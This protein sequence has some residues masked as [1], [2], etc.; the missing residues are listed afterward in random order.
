MKKILALCLVF[1]MVVPLLVACNNKPTDT[2]YYELVSVSKKGDCYTFTY[3]DGENEVTVRN[4]KDNGNK[5]RVEMGGMNMFAYYPDGNKYIL[6]LSKEV[7][8]K[9]AAGD[10]YEK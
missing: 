10:V 9:L 4:F 5:K 8:D 6:F 7:L 2:T 3:L 1:V